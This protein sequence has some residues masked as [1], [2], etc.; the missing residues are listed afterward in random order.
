MYSTYPTPFT[1]YAYSYTWGG[2]LPTSLNSQ[3][4]CI[5]TGMHD[6]LL[7]SPL[8]PPKPSDPVEFPRDG[9]E[10]GWTADLYWDELIVEVAYYKS[11]F[12]SVAALHM[13]T[14]PNMTAD[15]MYWWGTAAFLTETS[16]FHEQNEQTTFAIQDP[17]SAIP[18]TPPPVDANPTPT[19]SDEG[20]EQSTIASTTQDSSLGTQIPSPTLDPSSSPISSN[21][22]HKEKDQPTVAT[23]QDSSSDTSTAPFI[24]DANPTP[25]SSNKE[26]SSIAVASTSQ[27][28]GSDIPVVPPTIDANSTPTSSNKDNEQ[29]TVSSATQNSNP[30]I[31]ISPST[32][33]A[34]PSPASSD[35]KTT[36]SPIGSTT[37]DSGSSTS[38]VS[39]I[40]VTNPTSPVSHKQNDLPTFAIQDPVSVAP[41]T[42]PTADATP[43]PNN[44]R[45]EQVQPPAVSTAQDSGSSAA[46]TLPGV[47]VNPTPIGS[48]GRF[49]FVPPVVLSSPA[50]GETIARQD[51]S[52]LASNIP[53]DA[54]S[55]TQEQSPVSVIAQSIDLGATSSPDDLASSGSTDPSV[56]G[57]SSELPTESAAVADSLPVARSSL[58]PEPANTPLS[59]QI[60]T[61]SIPTPAPPTLTIGTSV[62]TANSATQFEIAPGINVA[63]GGAAQTVSGTT[64]SLAPSASYIAVNGVTS[65]LP[66]ASTPGLIMAPPVLTIGGS[67]YTANSATEYD[68]APGITVAPGGPAGTISGTTISLA[69]SASYL[70][71]NDVSSPLK[72]ASSASMAP[73]VLTIGGSVYTAN[74]A[75]QHEIAPGI[76]VAPG[77]PAQ[78]VSGTT[79]SLESSAS[80]IAVND[81]TSIFAAAASASS[82][83]QTPP[84]LTIGDS[85][86]TANSATQYEIAPGIT[87]VP[88]GPPGTISGTT[89]SLAPSASYVAVNGVTSTL[90]VATLPSAPSPTSPTRT[91][92]GGVY[93]AQSES[94]YSI[95]GQTL[96]LGSS[97]TVG[98]QS[99]TM[100]V[101]LQTATNGATELV[102]SV[103]NSMSTSTLTSGGAPISLPVVSP[104]K[105][106]PPLTV[107]GRT[108]SANSLTQYSLAQDVTLTPGGIVTFNGTEISLAPSGSFAVVGSSTET[109]SVAETARTTGGGASGGPGGSTTSGLNGG[110][111]SDSSITPA[112]VNGAGGRM[113]Q[114]SSGLCWI[115]LI[116]MIVATGCLAVAW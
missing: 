66:L 42:P 109:L 30:D 63:P 43:T 13:C 58:S 76:T 77:G 9:G 81:V 25:T 59:N 19:S 16:I 56:L 90:E 10:L 69:P 113:S 64:I 86:Y 100:L 107:G 5:T 39:P 11:A 85:T 53:V 35:D 40:V 8:P 104:T 112:S 78:K 96:A 26:S 57:A 15:P 4:T 65:T 1:D 72:P 23:A 73:P 62:F 114:R 67:T 33:D 115:W 116:G 110:N 74:R 52:F 28:S 48:S 84:V 51:N 54:P 83:S 49:T 70:A 108:Y 94:Q 103:G 50:Q 7:P 61:D 82:A 111:P 106:P 98:S 79:I 75:T 2:V 45:E 29:S 32:V 92:G 17:V 71:I 36:R 31:P 88:G 91:F 93:T 12:P 101:E 68:I 97:I 80:Y 22:E 46:I 37:E 99:S 6:E 20:N 102:V 47:D 27:D 89:I 34:V 21:K 38:L 44:S 55:T 60:P 87:V 95:E 18:K 14:I 41:I 3:S 105:A 24:V